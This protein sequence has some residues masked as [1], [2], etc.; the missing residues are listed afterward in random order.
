[1]YKQNKCIHIARALAG[2]SAWPGCY[3]IK[4]CTSFIMH[5]Y[6]SLLQKTKHSRYTFYL[7][8]Y[9]KDLHKLIKVYACR[10]ES[11]RNRWLYLLLTLLCMEHMHVVSRSHSYNA[12]TE[13]VYMYTEPRWIVDGGRAIYW[14][15]RCIHT[16]RLL[17]HVFASMVNSHLDDQSSVVMVSSIE[18]DMD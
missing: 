18:V 16:S 8:M 11:I 7:Y 15:A 9:S 5:T 2:E 10:Y 1:M 12:R 14:T 17:M 4:Q 6:I 3:I 13:D